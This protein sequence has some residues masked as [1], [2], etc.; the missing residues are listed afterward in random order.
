MISL[1]PTFSAAQAREMIETSK[2]KATALDVFWGQVIGAI[3]AS[4][5]TVAEDVA[6]AEAGAG[7]LADLLVP[8]RSYA[9]HGA[10]A[11]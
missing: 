10:K 7:V 4:G 9:K 2:S 6:I 3:G 11:K 8:A 1:K 5:G